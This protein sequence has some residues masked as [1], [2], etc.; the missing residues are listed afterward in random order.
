M[1]GIPTDPN[2]QTPMRFHPVACT[3]FVTCCQPPYNPHTSCKT[4]HLTHPTTLR[5]CLGAFVIRCIRYFVV[6]R[7]LFG[8][9]LRLVL[10]HQLLQTLTLHLLV[11]MRSY[12]LSAFANGLTSCNRLVYGRL[13]FKSPR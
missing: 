5:A 2:Y 11:D 4:S 12:S 13:I 3:Q 1:S 8:A 6:M 9:T 7:L 10:S